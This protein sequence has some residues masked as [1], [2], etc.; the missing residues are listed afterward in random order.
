MGANRI[1]MGYTPATY[2][3]GVLAFA[4]TTSINTN[5]WDASV[6]FRTSNG[7]IV[8]EISVHESAEAALAHIAD[9]IS[10]MGVAK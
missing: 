8:P 10:E 9:T 1:S 2:I 7:G 6:T 5:Q 4:A 3:Q